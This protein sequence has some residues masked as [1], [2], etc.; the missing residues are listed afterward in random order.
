M[1]KNSWNAIVIGVVLLFAGMLAAGCSG[2]KKAEKDA[3][4]DKW[5]TM[6]QTATGHSPVFKPK[7]VELPPEV[8][9]SQPAP[10]VEA[11]ELPKMMVSLKMRQADVK[12]VLRSLARIAHQN[13]L[14]KNE[15]KGEIT[16]DFRGISWDQAFTSI[17]RAQ[18]LTYIWEGQILRVISPEDMDRDMKI[19][20][21]TE[22]RRANEMASKLIDPLHIVIVNVDYADIK[23]M[24][25]NLQEFLTKDKE[26]KPRGSVK[27]D[28]HS[29]SL[30][31][32]AIRDDLTR[33]IPIIE[34]I[35]KPTP[36]ILIKAHIVET[37]KETARQL[38]ILWGG[39]YKAG[40]GNHNLYVTPGGGSAGDGT[41]KA[42]F[43]ATGFT[44]AGMGVYLPSF[45][46]ATEGSPYGALGL[47]FGTL[48]GNI[49][50]VQ[51]NALQTEGVLNIL[52][53]PSITTLD[54]QKAY[55]ENGEKVPVVSTDN[56]GNRT[57][58]YEDAVL[59]LEIKPHVI[60]G[61]NLKMGIIVKKDEVDTTRAVDNNP[62]IIKKQTETSLI[63]RD[64][65]TIVIS[66]LTKQNTQKITTGLP[67][68]KDIPGLGWLFKGEDKS[69][70]MQ[71]VLV[72]ITPKIL[73]PY[74]TA[75][76]E[77]PNGKKKPQEKPEQRATVPGS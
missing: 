33:M 48:A 15:I 20:A 66:G 65:E 3:F 19:E 17:L 5:H 21:L 44:G 69:E 62:F 68:L 31:I 41:G 1:K 51:L 77:E 26:G 46:G 4:F 29:N 70:T 35:D 55:T 76:A 67:A 63:V 40:V 24:Q 53:S 30:I 8:S 12:A 39:S 42:T 14:I 22:K 60:D 10:G 74:V 50:E 56:E 23:S 7:S 25:T 32:H 54:N 34:K 49:V 27:V 57:V 59:R 43:P 64:G 9:K 6:S 47:S 28:E 75:A 13:I 18:G 45:A 73:P 52:S 61:T 36:Q 16:V 38:G 2:P 71:E 11:K 72:F 37:T 58:K